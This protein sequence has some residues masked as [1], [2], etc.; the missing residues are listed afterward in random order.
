MIKITTLDPHQPDMLQPKLSILSEFIP[1]HVA[2]IKEV[3]SVC[4]SEGRIAMY[5][6]DRQGRL[7]P[8]HDQHD[9]HTAMITSICRIK[10]LDIFVTVS[11]DGSSVSGTT[12]I[13]YSAKSTSPSRF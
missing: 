13:L 2:I 4:S 11:V 6:L 7:L 9:Q 1:I 5:M 3:V 10:K 12:A 8:T